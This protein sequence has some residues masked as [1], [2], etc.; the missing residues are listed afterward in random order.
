MN[1]LEKLQE[2]NQY[3]RAQHRKIF[4]AGHNNDCIY[5]GFKDRIAADAANLTTGAAPTQVERLREAAKLAET[6]LSAEVLETKDE[7]WRDNCREDLAKV[8]AILKE[9]A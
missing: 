7:T 6:F 4:D 8:Q 9:T 5:C 3:L 2:E 1:E